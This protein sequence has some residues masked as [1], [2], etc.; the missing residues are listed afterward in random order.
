LKLAALVSGVDAY[1]V[2]M[3]TAAVSGQSRRWTAS[4]H[5]HEVQ[6]NFPLLQSK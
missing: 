4:W 1:V 3:M 6:C 5:H 2:C